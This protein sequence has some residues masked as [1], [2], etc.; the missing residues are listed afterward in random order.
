MTSRHQNSNQVSQAH[1][2]VLTQAIKNSIPPRRTV[3]IGQGG[4]KVQ[5]VP[6]QSLSE[7]PLEASMSLNSQRCRLDYWYS[8]TL[9]KLTLLYLLVAIGRA[10]E[11]ALENRIWNND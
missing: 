6:S 7:C 9:Q 11:T 4:G 10:K 3:T 8:H 1:S 2:H 5:T